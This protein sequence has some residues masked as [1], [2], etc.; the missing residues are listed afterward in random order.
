MPASWIPLAASVAGGLLGSQGSQQSQTQSNKM[1]SRLDPYVYGS[2]GQGG[3]LG[4]AND[5]FQANKTGLNPQMLQGLNSQWQTLN[6][7]A[8]MGAY[9]QM[10]NLGSSLMSAPVMGN[11]FSDGRASLSSQRPQ[12]L[13]LSQPQQRFSAPSVTFGGGSQGLPAG[14]FAMPQSAPQQ[15]QAPQQANQPTLTQEQANWL[16]T[17]LQNQLMNRGS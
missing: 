2:N 3:I 8:A 17:M 5:W 16:N 1:D 9:R 15:S 7:P 11:P 4:A 6:D 10:G 12:N 14:P 13:G